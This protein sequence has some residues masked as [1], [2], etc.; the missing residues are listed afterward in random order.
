MKIYLP[1][2]N[3]ALQK[4]KIKFINRLVY[5]NAINIMKNMC[6]AI[7]HCLCCPIHLVTK[8]WRLLKVF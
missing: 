4:Q 3:I 8:T 1:Y 6:T 5:V 7:C 2:Y